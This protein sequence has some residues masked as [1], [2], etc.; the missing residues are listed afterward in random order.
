MRTGTTGPA[1]PAIAARLAAA[2]PV[3]EQLP[4]E[5]EHEARV[6]D[7][8]PPPETARL[9][10]EP[11]R[12]L[13]PDALERARGLALEAGVEVE[14]GAD[15]DQHRRYEAVAHREHELLLERDAEADP[16]HVGRRGVELAGDRVGLV[17]GQLAGGTGAGADDAQAR[18]APRKLL[19]QRPERR[20]AAAVKEEGL[21]GAGRALAR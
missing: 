16:D 12:P 10:D 2:A 8:V 14:G 3:R 18:V 19:A 9:L 20:L 13:E 15:T 1:A 7:Q 11:E 5:P 6:V 21:A 17:A 4:G